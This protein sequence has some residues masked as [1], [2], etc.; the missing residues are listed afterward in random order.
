[1]M[2]IVIAFETA[3]FESVKTANEIYIELKDNISSFEKEVNLL[4][5][6]K[7]YLA[8]FDEL[9]GFEYLDV[10]AY[11]YGNGYILEGQD[12][13]IYVEIKDKMIV[14]INFR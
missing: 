2:A 9:D 4:N 8:N 7:C 13:K 6:A 5:E 3:Y 11:R 10:E 1:M 12:L 14:Y